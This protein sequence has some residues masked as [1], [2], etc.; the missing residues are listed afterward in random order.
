LPDD[1]SW[2][3]QVL[4]RFFYHFSLENALSVLGRNLCTWALLIRVYAIVLGSKEYVDDVTH[5]SEYTL[6]ALQSPA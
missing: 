1:D 6:T 2:V 3:L 4:I 5:V